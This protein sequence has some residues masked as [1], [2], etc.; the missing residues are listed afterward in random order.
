MKN[1]FVQQVHR[2]AVTDPIA[3]AYPYDY[4][5][6]FEVRL[7]EPDLH[8]PETWVRSGLDSTPE[9][10]DQIASLLGLGS[11]PT[12]SEDRVDVFRVVKSDAEV[13]QLEA[14]VPLM[15][16]VIVGRR[17]TPTQRMLTSILHY[18]RPRLA[19]LV[20]AVIGFG[21]RW[22]VPQV[23]TSKVSTHEVEQKD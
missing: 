3:T 5:D 17:V 12:S 16:I 13:V 15:H 18:K 2:V 11:A 19:R 1:Q 4:A 22:A 23:L 20:W 6:A 9:W 8:P 21:H 7:P 10:M 14:S